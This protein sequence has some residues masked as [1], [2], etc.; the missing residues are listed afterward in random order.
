MKT[1]SGALPELESVLLY[2]ITFET[3]MERSHPVEE[4]CDVEPP[5][6]LH[7]PTLKDSTEEETLTITFYQDT[8]DWRIARQLSTLYLSPQW[9]GSRARLEKVIAD[10]AVDRMYDWI[11]LQ[12]WKIY[13]GRL[14]NTLSSGEY[15]L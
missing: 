11:P 1:V 3:L 5:L 6:L 10:T 14:W 9:R 7:S 13:E 12:L 4:K 2:P 8:L 15:S